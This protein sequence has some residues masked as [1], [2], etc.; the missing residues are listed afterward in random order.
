[1]EDPRDK[2]LIIGNYGAGKALAAAYRQAELNSLR[3]V[4]TYNLAPGE[5]NDEFFEQI[6]GQ[7]VDVIVGDLEPR[8]FMVEETGNRKERRAARARNRDKRW[9]IKL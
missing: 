9:R 8:R 2:I 3:E 5:T 1:M 6:R 4:Q 7:T